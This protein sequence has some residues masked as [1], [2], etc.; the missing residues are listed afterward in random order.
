MA[1]RYYSSMMRLNRLQWLYLRSR[2]EGFTWPRGCGGMMHWF[3]K[4]GLVEKLVSNTVYTY[5]VTEKGYLSTVMG[6]CEYRK[7][8]IEPY[9]WLKDG[10]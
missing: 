1:K 6:A 8:G 10:Q 2:R 9:P 7:K 3:L 5:R 4:H